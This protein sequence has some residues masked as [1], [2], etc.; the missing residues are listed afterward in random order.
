MHAAETSP[1]RS[2]D[3]TAR[4]ISRFFTEKQIDKLKKD[5][6]KSPKYRFVIDNVPL[7]KRTHKILEIGCS[8][9]Y[10]TSY[11]ILAGSDIIGT[12]VS[13]TAIE[14]ARSIFGDH[15]VQMDDACL[16]RSNYFDIIYHVGTIGC[17]NDPIRFTKKLLKLLKP[18][19]RLLFNAPDVNAV[20]EM[21][22]I[23]TNLTPPP[24]LITLFEERFWEELFLDMAAVEIEYHPYSHY[25]NADKNR[26]KLFNIDYLNSKQKQF[27]QLESQVMGSHLDLMGTGKKMVN[28]FL[29]KLSRLRL[30]K[31][32]KNEF[33]MF[34]TLTKKQ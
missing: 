17:V 7:K 5:L 14:K 10:L 13:P 15:F 25:R 28:G 20:K 21:K 11:F 1:Y 30:I 23:W 29:C 3:K 22:A 4:R 6:L 34:V 32:Y 19:G 27:F 31:H 9:G 12:D 26:H 2:H 8:L 16:S 24:D 33:G 18:G